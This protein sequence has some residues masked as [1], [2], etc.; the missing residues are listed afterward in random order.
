MYYQYDGLIIKGPGFDPLKDTV[1]LESE[2]FKTKM[3][4][5]SD[6][7]QALFIA[8]ELVADGVNTIELSGDFGELWM[9]QLTSQI[10]I[11]HPDSEVD[12]RPASFTPICGFMN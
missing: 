10:K 7:R 3:V 5:V 2:H 9:S 4:G 8:E 6:P 12:F 1:T 11:N